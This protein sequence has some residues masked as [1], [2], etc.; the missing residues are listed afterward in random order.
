MTLKI[1]DRVPDVPLNQMTDAGPGPVSRQS[2]FG[3]RTVAIFAVP[4]AFTP[5]CSDQ[6]MPSVIQNIGP[7]H[8]AGVDLIACLSVNDIFVMRAWG[9]A[10]GVGDDVAMLADGS[11]DWTKAAGLDWDLSPLGL[12]VRSQRYAMVVDDT[13]VRHLAIEPGGAFGVSS[14]SAV[15]AAL[16]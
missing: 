7:L 14:G 15:V 11:A 1:G 5:T 6:H 4:G 9:R 13:V 12:G 8:D 2:L 16:R 3:G 10:L